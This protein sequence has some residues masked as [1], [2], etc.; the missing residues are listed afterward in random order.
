MDDDFDPDPNSSIVYLA[1]SIL[2]STQNSLVPEILYLFSPRQ[3]IEF[4]KVFGG[5]TL[6]VPTSNEFSKDLLAG[7]ACYHLMV[8]NKSWDYVILKYDLDGNTVKS[9]KV[10][11]GHWWNNLSPAEKD[12]V[13]HLK[14]HEDA[15]RQQET[16]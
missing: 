9:L 7:I 4:I 2:C 14:G 1:L 10:K 16:V 6:H 15:R 3:I 8:E 13:E 5:E 12:F 11:V